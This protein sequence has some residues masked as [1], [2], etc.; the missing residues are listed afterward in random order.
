M[1]GRMWTWWWRLLLGSVAVVI[2]A[3]L[4]HYKG[5][6][7]ADLDAA[8]YFPA[9]D[10]IVLETLPFSGDPRLKLWRQW[11]EQLSQDPTNLLLAVELAGQYVR[12]GHMNA[13]PRYDGY[14]RA[15]LFPWWDDPTPPVEVL[16]LRATLRQ[17]VH[18]F[19]AALEDLSKILRTNPRHTQAWLTK[20]VIHQVRGEYAE[21]RQ[22][23]LPL[24]G[25]VSALVVSSCVANAVGAT[26]QAERSLE[27]LQRG[28]ERH[29]S[30]TTQETLWA[31]TIL[32][33]TSGRLGRSTQAED[34][35]QQALKIEPSD[36]YL[37]GA[38]SD[39][40][41]DHDRSGEVMDLFPGSNLPDALLLRA[42]LASKRLN[43]P[44]TDGLMEDLRNRFRE[45]R[46]RGDSRHLREEARFTLVLLADPAE[47]LKLAQENWAVQREPW[48]TRL[49]LEASLA[50]GNTDAAEPVL[51]WIKDVDLEDRAIRRVMESF[52]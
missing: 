9:E 52:S 27:Q 16:L 46:L 25:Q 12:A 29:D 17:R 1:R 23:C 13:D 19:D 37:L 47:A 41:L 22:S 40:L 43:L 50:A 30:A 38:Y 24:V 11:E 45:S 31:L 28:I 14:A 7:V 15:A 39:W 33:E 6:P 2:L 3:A 10:E 51:Q 26:G 32:A 20:S 35:F 49:V 48:D 36:T 4:G 42:A 5:S 8:P 21:A 44:Q 34:Y 18:Q